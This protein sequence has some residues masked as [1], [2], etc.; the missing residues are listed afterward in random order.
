[1]S[2]KKEEELCLDRGRIK[3]RVKEFKVNSQSP[4]NGSIGR[5]ELAKEGPSDCNSPDKI[6]VEFYRMTETGQLPEQESGRDT[7]WD[8]MLPF[9]IAHKFIYVRFNHDDRISSYHSQA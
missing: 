1:M 6:I 8:S 5:V 7:A 9:F 4:V 3:Y 2:E